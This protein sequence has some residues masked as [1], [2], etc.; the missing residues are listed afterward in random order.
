MLIHF[1]AGYRK[2]SSV[3]FHANFCDPLTPIVAS[4]TQP[5]PTHIHLSSVLWAV[6]L[7]ML[8]RFALV[9]DTLVG[10]C[11]GAVTATRL[12]VSK[13][14]SSKFK[15]GEQIRRENK[16][17]VAKLAALVALLAL[18]AVT[19]IILALPILIVGM[20]LVRDMWPL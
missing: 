13:S 5:R 7:Q 3:C 6:R 11:L 1:Y 10:A 4:F 19:Y 9:A 14:M 20:K 17:Q 18:G 12:Q 16:P 2:N 8:V 15:L